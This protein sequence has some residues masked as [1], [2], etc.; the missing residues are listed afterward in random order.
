MLGIRN[1]NVAYLKL[2]TLNILELFDLLQNKF[3]CWSYFFMYVLMTK[4][5]NAHDEQGFLVA[6]FEVVA[7]AVSILGWD[8]PC[9]FIQQDEHECLSP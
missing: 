7:G 1:N 8:N 5:C 9:L 4:H 2:V 3:Q 6:L